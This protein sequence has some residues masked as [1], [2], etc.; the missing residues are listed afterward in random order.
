MFSNFCNVFLTDV[1]GQVLDCGDV[2]TINCAGGYQRKKL[3]FTLRDIKD[4]GD[5]KNL[6][7]LA[8]NDES[9]PLSNK[10]V[11]QPDKRGNRDK[12]LLF[13]T[14]NIHEMKASTQVSVLKPFI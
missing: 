14:K 10:Q 12:W 2:E 11:D 7:T 13:P 1:L 6:M 5:E 3:E 9:H 8:S 4:T